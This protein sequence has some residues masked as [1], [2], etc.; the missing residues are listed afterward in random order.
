ML[1]CSPAS[2]DEIEPS[3][4][5]AAEAR[6]LNRVM[7]PELAVTPVLAVKAFFSSVWLASAASSLAL[8]VVRLPSAFIVM[9]IEDSVPKV[10]EALLTWLITPRNAHCRFTAELSPCSAPAFLLASSYF[11]L[12]RRLEATLLKAVTKSLRSEERRVGKE[13]RSR[14]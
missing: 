7:K 14:W 12:V 2:R 6:L 10:D 11:R 8:L 13:C 1:A 5:R 9:P 4:P 3:V